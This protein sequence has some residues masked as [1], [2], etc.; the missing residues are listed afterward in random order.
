MSEN[1]YSA[2]ENTHV[3]LLKDNYSMDIQVYQERCKELE[4][5][6]MEARTAL[7]E[8]KL[9]SKELEDALEQELEY[10]EKQYEML[11]E[12]N[13]CLK[14]E[15][16]RWKVKYEEIQLENLAST[17][18]MEEE[19][20]A[21]REAH[22]LNKSKI[23]D[24]ELTNDAME[25]KERVVQSS[26]EELEIKYN[27]MIEENV[28]LE[29]E[30]TSQKSL[31]IEHQRLKDELRDTQLEL[32]LVKEKLAQ[33]QAEKEEMISRALLLRPARRANISNE[34]TITS[35]EDKEKEKISEDLSPSSKPKI[36]ASKIKER[37]IRSHS[38][39]MMQEMSKHVKNLESRL[40]SCRIF[41]KPLL[42][43]SRFLE[44]PVSPS[45]PSKSIENHEKIS[46]AL[47]SSENLF[48]T[49]LSE[50][51]IRNTS[52][53]PLSKDESLIQHSH[54]PV[55]PVST[56]IYKPPYTSD[57]SDASLSKTNQ[58]KIIDQSKNDMV[59]SFRRLSI[60]KMILDMNLSKSPKRQIIPSAI[61]VYSE[62]SKR[63][64]SGIP[65]KTSP[66][67]ITNNHLRKK[68]SALELFSNDAQQKVIHMSSITNLS[69]H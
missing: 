4:E 55:T 33:A 15:V 11:K 27:K 9:T 23:T 8:F 46:N 10:T 67:K 60:K 56:K 21:L 44:Q 42:L 34:K 35:F 19:I 30:L 58:E 3:S 13:T 68:N 47:K 7:D 12:E 22:Q 2:Y 6:V 49:P 29:A 40:Q 52:S 43:R 1:E 26:F 5:A 14:K 39:R 61:P 66:E 53:E 65:Q 17:V 31:E 16:E 57:T 37:H 41:A 51:Q 25:R 32:S 69:K 28:F 64:T 54:E 50:S 38:V 20:E 62:M 36:S 24:L 63:R 45:L 59:R 48:I 18:A